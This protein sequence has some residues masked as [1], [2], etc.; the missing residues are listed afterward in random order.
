MTLKWRVDADGVNPIGSIQNETYAGG[1]EVG[2]WQSV[3]MTGADVPTPAGVL[4]ASV[5]ARRYGG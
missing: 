1:P 3:V 4:A 2:A 5:K